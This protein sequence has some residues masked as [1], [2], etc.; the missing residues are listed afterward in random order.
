M[1]S[2]NNNINPVYI[3]LPILAK[4]GYARDKIIS[5]LLKNGIVATRSYP[6]AICDIPEIQ[7]ELHANDRTQDSGQYIANRIITLP[8]HPYVKERH[9]SK[10]VDIIRQSCSQ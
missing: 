10:I 6:K 3:R 5:N 1:I 2:H 8:V 9:I 4:D 7:D